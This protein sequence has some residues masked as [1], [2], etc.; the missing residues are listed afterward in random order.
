[1][2]LTPEEE[3]RLARED[4]V[5]DLTDTSGVATHEQRLEEKD[6]LELRLYLF[7]DEGQWLVSADN[8]RYYPARLAFNL[9]RYDVREVE[10]T[11]LIRAGSSPDRRL[12]RFRLDKLPYDL[13]AGL[14]DDLGQVFGNASAVEFLNA[15]GSNFDPVYPAVILFGKVKVDT[16]RSYTLPDGSSYKWFSNAKIEQADEQDNEIVGMDSLH[17]WTAEDYLK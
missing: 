14:K 7:Q 13:L 2:A 5:Q 9:K 11:G 3:E 17:I 4:F 12:K 10:K 8:Q 1:M 16:S 15:D 6:F